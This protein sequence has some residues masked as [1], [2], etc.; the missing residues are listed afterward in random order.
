MVYHVI[1]PFRSILK[2]I[3]MSS[4]QHFLSFNLPCVP[5]ILTNSRSYISLILA[6]RYFPHYRSP[7]ISHSLLFILSSSHFSSSFI[8]HHSLISLTHLT[9]FLPNTLT[10]SLPQLPTSF[11]HYNLKIIKDSQEFGAKSKEELAHTLETNGG[12]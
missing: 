5:L 8:T 1:F 10:F 7:P 6:I 9:L 2:I 11:P 4:S 3:H 12:F